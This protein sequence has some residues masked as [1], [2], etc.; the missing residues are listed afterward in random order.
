MPLCFIYKKIVTDNGIK[1]FVSFQYMDNVSNK[2]ANFLYRYNHTH[3]LTS[4]VVVVALKPSEQLPVILLAILKAGMV[5]LPLD[6]E[7]PI[8][9]IDF[10]LR[11][12]SPAMCIVHETGILL[13]PT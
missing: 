2:I 9:R 5:Y 8:G 13:Q 12:T 11:E 10:I 6:L 4:K 1:N 7:S 3:K